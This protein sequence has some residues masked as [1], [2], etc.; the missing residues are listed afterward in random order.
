[1][2]PNPITSDPKN[3]SFFDMLRLTLCPNFTIK[4]ATFAL[5]AIVLISLTQ[6]TI[7]YVVALFIGPMG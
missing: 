2:G 5:I 7:F 4:S 6:D 3:E 1:M